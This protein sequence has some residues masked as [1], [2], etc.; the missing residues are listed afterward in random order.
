MKAALST[1]AEQ[2]LRETVLRHARQMEL[3]NS[4]TMVALGYPDLPNVFQMLIDRLGRL[5]DKY[6]NLVGRRA[7]ALCAYRG[8]QADAGRVSEPQNL[9]W[10]AND[11]G[12]RSACRARSGC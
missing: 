8:L 11:D 7:P 4:I 5:F 3:L 6:P 10:G 1:H 12:V 9:S 2:S